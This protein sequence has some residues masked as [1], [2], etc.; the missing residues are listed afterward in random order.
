MNIKLFIKTHLPF[1]LKNRNA[2]NAF[3]KHYFLPKFGYSDE[4]A[5]IGLPII[6]T[7]PQN[8]FLYERTRINPGAKIITYTGKVIIKKYTEIAFGCT[9]ITGNHTPTV[10]FPQTTLGHSHL[11][12]KERDIVIEEDVWIGANVTILSGT[13]ISRGCVVGACSLVNREIP[14]YAVVVGSPAKIIASKFTLE[15]ILEHETKIYAPN[16]RF[17]REYLENLFLNYYNGMHSIG[18]NG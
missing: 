8:V 18:L 7:R 12:D 9:I 15:Q 10:G 5:Q 16:E 1:L 4:S 6:V 11:N 14:P 3:R 13:H 17:T 2:F